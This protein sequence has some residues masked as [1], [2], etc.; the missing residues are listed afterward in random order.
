MKAK[1]IKYHPYPKDNPEGYT[2][3]FDITLSNGRSFYIDTLL[4]FDEIGNNTVDEQIIDLALKKLNTKIEERR[5]QLAEIKIIVGSAKTI[6][7][8]ILSSK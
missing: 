4:S 6:P 8:L 7:P 5:A 1:V 2:V 3:G